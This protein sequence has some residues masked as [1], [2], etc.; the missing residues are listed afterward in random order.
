M[1][2]VDSFGLLSYI[3]GPRF[4][5]WYIQK[6][7]QSAN[8]ILFYTIM[9]QHIN[10][11][12][13]A[14]HL[15]PQCPSTSTNNLLPQICWGFQRCP[16]QVLRTN[17]S[18]YTPDVCEV[19]EWLCLYIRKRYRVYCLYTYSIRPPNILLW[20]IL[21]PLCCSINRS[22]MRKLCAHI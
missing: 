22:K 16:H 15:K 7:P 8:Y 21:L 1:T 17:W 19:I 6:K 9:T 5:M 20:L 3:P 18:V 12:T 11:R 2:E 4:G 13:D 10:N 14:V